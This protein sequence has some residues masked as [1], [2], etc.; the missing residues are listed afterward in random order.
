MTNLPP[1]AK[2]PSRP[3]GRTWLFWFLLICVAFVG[4]LYT[5]KAVMALLV[6]ESDR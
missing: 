6:K 1:L 2:E 5:P 3:L 4:S